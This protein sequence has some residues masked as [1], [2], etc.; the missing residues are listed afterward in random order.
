MRCNQGIVSKLC[1]NCIRTVVYLIILSK[2]PRVKMALNMGGTLTPNSPPSAL[3]LS[4][5]AMGEGSG[6]PSVVNIHLG[7]DIGPLVEPFGIVDVEVDAAM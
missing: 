4:P 7:A 6:R 5:I 2:L 3:R 1:P